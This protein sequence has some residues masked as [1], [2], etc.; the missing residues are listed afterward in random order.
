MLTEILED[1]LQQ[2]TG[3]PAYRIQRIKAAKQML[4]VDANGEVAI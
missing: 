3:G 1:Y 2:N 4:G